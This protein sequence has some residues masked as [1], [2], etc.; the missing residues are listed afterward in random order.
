[1]FWC[2]D[3]LCVLM[4]VCPDVLGVL[5]ALV[6]STFCYQETIVRRHKSVNCLLKLHLKSVYLCYAPLVTLRI[7]SG[8]PNPPYFTDFFG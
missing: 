6:V 2:M 8:Y 1:M 5:A 4:I 7:P 3:C